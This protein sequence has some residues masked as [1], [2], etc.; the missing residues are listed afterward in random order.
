MSKHGTEQREKEFEQFVK[1]NKGK[2]YT[3][4]ALK[5]FIQNI[6]EIVT[7]DELARI[8]G[9][10]GKPIS[11]N[12]RRIFELRDEKG[13][14]II[15]HKDETKDYNLKVD[16]WVMLV[17]EPNPSKIRTRGVTTKLRAEVLERDLNTCQSCGRTIGD[18]DPFKAGHRIT[19]HIGHLKAHKGIDGTI[20]NIDVEL[21]KDDYIT[22]CNV[23]NEG[24]K[25]KDIVPITFMDRINKLK[26]EEQLEVLKYLEAKFKRK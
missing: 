3:A 12:M 4:T 18:D 1:E 13:F 17:E 11:H 2:S 21:T 25:N 6:N 23:C 15:N 16:Q 19:L 24:Q 5:W 20:S 14:E 26:E 22:Q 7:S 9:K 8:P 10:D